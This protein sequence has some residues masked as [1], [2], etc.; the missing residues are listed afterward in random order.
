MK[1][2][3]IHEIREAGKQIPYDQ[4]VKLVRNL[5]S[6]VLLEA[7]KDYCGEVSENKKHGLPKYYFDKSTILRDLKS[8]RL[9]RLSDGLSLT[10]AHQLK[11][12][13]AAI[14]ENIK[15]I[16]DDCNLVKVET[17]DTPQYR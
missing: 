14:I 15:T 2:I 12:N 17:Y 1:T 4:K 10:V 5:M 8:E 13:E 6:V 9:I 16:V 11:T 7:V 3:D